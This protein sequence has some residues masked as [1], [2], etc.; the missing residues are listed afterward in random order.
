MLLGRLCLLAHL[1]V[2][3]VGDAARLG[4]SSLIPPAPSCT[5]APPP[6]APSPSGAWGPSHLFLVFSVI[7]LLWLVNSE[8]LSPVEMQVDQ[9]WSG[10]SLGLFLRDFGLEIC[11]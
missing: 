9:I 4:G 5:V 6:G 10:L 2:S 3:P 7:P 1:P 8:Q 11:I